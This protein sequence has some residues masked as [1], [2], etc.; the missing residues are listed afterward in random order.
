[1][2]PRSV[3]AFMLPYN[4][5]ITGM[6]SPASLGRQWLLMVA[7]TGDIIVHVDIYHDGLYHITSSGDE[8]A[9]LTA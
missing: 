8:S 9:T 2:R 4:W 5:L 7:I 1:M 6:D 3:T